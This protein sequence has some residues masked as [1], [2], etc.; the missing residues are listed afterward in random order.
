[1]LSRR[2]DV[3]HRVGA[4]RA[5]MIRAR[6]EHEVI[7][8]EL[9]A[10]AEEV[11]QRFFAVRAVKDIAFFNLD[12]GQLP[13]FGAQGVQRM[14]HLEFLGQKRFSRREPVIA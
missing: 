3:I 11:D 13:A 4:A 7:D 2:V 6:R 14:G 12:P 8:G 9:T 1:M 5:N 10:I